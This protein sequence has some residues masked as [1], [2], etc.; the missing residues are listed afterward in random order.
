[1]KLALGSVQFGVD[2]GIANQHGQVPSSEVGDILQIA[3]K[4]GIEM[5]DT[6]ALYG[7]SEAVLGQFDA[8]QRFKLV[9][10]LPGNIHSEQIS[11]TISE[12]LLRLKTGRLY[13]LLLHAPEFLLGK[14]GDDIY[15]ALEQ[16]KTE[17]KVKKIGISV[18][19]PAL[20]KE[21]TERYQID[22]IQFPLNL[23][24]QRFIH[25]GIIDELKSRGVEL[26]ARSLLLQGLMLMREY[27]RYFER[28]ND[29]LYSLRIAA[30][31]QGVS[32]LAFLLGI[33]YQ[34]QNV[35]RF[36]LGCQSRM[37]LFSLLKHYAKAKEVELNY[38]SF[39]INDERLLLPS[40]W[41]NR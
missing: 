15:Q 11:S 3:Q 33:C 2:Y 19:C 28:W 30:K 31:E 21:I 25:S 14:Q 17:G 18:Y 1:M 40:N 32:L 23:F 35:D 8:G 38:S 29:Q 24:D 13:G 27:P 37:Q 34:N 6:A 9:T 26:H 39:S 20:T 4:H 5:L 36:V 41:P 10:K 7:N 16:L 22:L 12:S